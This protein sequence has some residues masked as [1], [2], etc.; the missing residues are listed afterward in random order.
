MSFESEMLEAGRAILLR[1]LE[2]T[3]YNMTQ[4]ARILQVNRTDLYKKLLKHGIERPPQHSP[5]GAHR[6]DWSSVQ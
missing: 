1:V 4:T 2:E 3:G 6:G 5:P